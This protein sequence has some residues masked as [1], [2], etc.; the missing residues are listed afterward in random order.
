MLVKSNISENPYNVRFLHFLPVWIMDFLLKYC[1]TSYHAGKTEI[2]K[3]TFIMVLNNLL[4]F[5]CLNFIRRTSPFRIPE[6]GKS[7]ISVANYARQNPY[8]KY[9]KKL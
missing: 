6:T 7:K 4:N 9:N 2:K 1:F 8:N 5:K 3:L